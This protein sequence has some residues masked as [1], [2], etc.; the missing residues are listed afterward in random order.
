M[1]PPHGSDIRTGGEVFRGNPLAARNGA[2]RFGRHRFASRLPES[3]SRV[4]FTGDEL[5]MPRPAAPGR[6][7]NSNR[8]T[9]MVRGDFRVRDPRLRDVPDCW[10]TREVLRA[11]RP[12]AM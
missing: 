2:R 9:S 4:V 7:Y 12:S 3:V 8:F 6:I 11:P 5:V 10:R 1:D